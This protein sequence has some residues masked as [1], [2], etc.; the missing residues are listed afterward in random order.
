MRREALFFT[1]FFLTAA[2]AWL[3]AAALLLVAARR[4]ACDYFLAVRYAPAMARAALVSV[5]LAV[6][7]GLIFDLYLRGGS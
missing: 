6:G 2:A 4:G 1:V 5:P 7:G 3:T